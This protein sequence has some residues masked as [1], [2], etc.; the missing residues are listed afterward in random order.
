MECSQAASRNPHLRAL[1]TTPLRF[2]A[3]PTLC[4]SERNQKG[5]PLR[6]V[7][8]GLSSAIQ[9]CRTYLLRRRALPRPSHMPSPAT[10][11]AHHRSPTLKPTPRSTPSN[12]RARAAY[13][14]LHARFLRTWCTASALPKR[15][16]SQQLRNRT[17]AEQGRKT[18]AVKLAACEYHREKV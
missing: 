1:A 10:H 11:M 6:T 9:H 14:K 13:A 7:T 8:Y 16:L 5:S 17:L 18:C 4:T 2:N 3:S 15:E 12:T